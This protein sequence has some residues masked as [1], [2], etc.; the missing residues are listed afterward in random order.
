M[1]FLNYRNRGKVSKSG[2]RLQSHAWLQ[3]RKGAIKVAKTRKSGIHTTPI[4]KIPFAS[5]MSQVTFKKSSTAEEKSQEIITG[6]SSAQKSAL[7][8]ALK[9]AVQ[10]R[11]T[12]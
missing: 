11:S 6:G 10:I 9:V 8:I 5:S 4:Q 7:I 3:A 2:K 1:I 12:A